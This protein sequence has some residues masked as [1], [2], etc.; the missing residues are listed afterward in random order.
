MKKQILITL[1]TLTIG[2]NSYANLDAAIKE[3]NAF[4]LPMVTALKTTLTKDPEFKKEF[5]EYAMELQKLSDVLN[6]IIREKLAI[7]INQK[8]KALFDQ[9]MKKSKVDPEQSKKKAK[10]ISKK[11]SIKGLNLFL[12]VGD[13][14]TYAA[15]ME[16]L[17][18]SEPPVETEVVFEAPFA[19]EHSSRGGNGTVRANLESGAFTADANSYFLGSY[20]NKAGLGDYIRIPWANR[21]V[22]V[23]AKLP[24]TSIH[25]S[26]FA[27]IGG[28][29]AK[30]SSL[31]E[32]Q[33]E[34][35]QGCS[36]T[37]EHGSVVAPVVWYNTLDMTDT[38]IMTC[39]M[40]SPPA[41]QDIT[42]QFQAVIEV[43]T[44][45]NATAIGHMSS[46]PAPIRVRLIQQ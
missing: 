24:E 28:S 46:T 26:A 20:K 40:R 34:D 42:V 17:Q 14:L 16:R 35:G 31:I 22:R 27:L 4:Q 19:F 9:A 43:T 12:R 8:H 39:E 13:Y 30:A 21:T 33:N 23:S 32:V 44:G 29:G 3:M 37:L 7:Q 2:L 45:A 18:N 41:N 11:Y 38:T 5:S 36:K 15:W 25:L 10:E 1:A 6:P